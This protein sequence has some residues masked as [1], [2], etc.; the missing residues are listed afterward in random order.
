MTSV[1]S[2]QDSFL[3]SWRTEQAQTCKFMIPYLMGVLCIRLFR[4]GCY[5][6]N[7]VVYSVK[8]LK[9]SLRLGQIDCLITLYLYSSTGTVL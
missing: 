6:C 2:W 1:A 7:C 8:S 4:G 9:L 3:P 5:M